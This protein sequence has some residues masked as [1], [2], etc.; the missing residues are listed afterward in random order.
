MKKQDEQYTLLSDN[1]KRQS[2]IVSSDIN[3]QVNT[4]RKKEKKSSM[5]LGA[6][7]IQTNKTVSKAAVA[8]K[9]GVQLRTQPSPDK[10]SN[11]LITNNDPASNGENKGE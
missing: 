1:V 8:F 6:D 4:G 7:K 11:N 3:K 5:K 10:A 2:M 9:K